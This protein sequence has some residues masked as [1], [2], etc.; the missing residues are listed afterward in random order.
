MRDDPARRTTDPLVLA[1]AS[2]LDRHGYFSL[3]V[4][5]DY[6]ASFIGRAR[7]FLEANARMPRTFGRNQIHVSQVEG[8]IEVDRPLVEVAPAGARRRRR[9][10]IAALVAERIPDGATIQ[11]GIG[12]IPNAILAALPATGTSACT[13]S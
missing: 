7:F 2:P 5:A 6:V 11:I 8:W 3:G 9:P 13:P 12:A 4:N 1:A 10:R